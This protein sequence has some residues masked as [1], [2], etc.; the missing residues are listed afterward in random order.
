MD[1]V[2][3]DM[4]AARRKF[5]TAFDNTK[6]A[7]KKREV[8]LTQVID[9]RSLRAT[10]RTEQFNFRVRADLKADIQEAARKAGIG[11][12]EW[13]ERAAEAMLKAGESDANA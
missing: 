1:D 9:R 4:A 6:S 11:V 13:L 7:R 12:A 5:N 10:G 3:F 8:S 2:V